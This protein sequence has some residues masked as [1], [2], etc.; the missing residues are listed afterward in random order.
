MKITLNSSYFTFS[1]EDE[2]Y[3]V[4]ISSSDRSYVI[5]GKPIIDNVIDRESDPYIL[6]EG[7]LPKGFIISADSTKTLL[8][9]SLSIKQ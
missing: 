1:I 8:L 3:E 9:K 7:F 4:L 2:E 6:A 5:M